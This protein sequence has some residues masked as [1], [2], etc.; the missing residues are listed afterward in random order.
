MRTLASDIASLG[1]GKGSGF[2]E[3][4]RGHTF[5]VGVGSTVQLAAEVGGTIGV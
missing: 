1:L 2:H 4:V 3:S 5:D